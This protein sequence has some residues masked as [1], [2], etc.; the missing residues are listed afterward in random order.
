M[1]KLENS[2]KVGLKTRIR[3]RF[4]GCIILHNDPNHMQGVP[5][6][7]V[8]FGKTWAMLEVKK[9]SRAPKQANQEHWIRI[10]GKMSFAAFIEP[11]NEGEVLDAM[12]SAFGLAREACLS[13]S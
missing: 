4:P 9:S 7:L 11:S 12:E 10:F 6:L 1:G 13:K 5:D 3:L 8:L 2:Y